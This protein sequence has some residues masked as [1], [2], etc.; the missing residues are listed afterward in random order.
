M[1]LITHSPIIVSKNLKE[2]CNKIKGKDIEEGILLSSFAYLTRK[3]GILRKK[4]TEY[5]LKGSYSSH[6]NLLTNLKKELIDIWPW[7]NE[8]KISDIEIEVV[9]KRKVIYFDIEREEFVEDRLAYVFVGETEIGNIGLEEEKLIKL[10]NACR[11]FTEALAT[12]EWKAIYETIPSLSDF[13][14]ELKSKWVKEV[15]LPLRIGYWTDDPYLGWLISF[16][17]VKEIR[18]HL[19][20]KLKKD[21]YPEKIL[22]SPKERAT[23]GW[24]YLID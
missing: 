24:A 6:E 4:V 22:Y 21:P 5:V 13:Y 7:L 11:S 18:E 3:E 23:F 10:S 8:I 1:K 19:K 17:R 9:Q 20:R 2:K 12:F 16:W 15:K 14:E